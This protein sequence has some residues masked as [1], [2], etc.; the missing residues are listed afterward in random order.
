MEVAWRGSGRVRVRRRRNCEGKDEPGGC[1]RV[2]GGKQ[3]KYRHLFA[4]LVRLQWAWYVRYMCSG[5]MTMWYRFCC[6]TKLESIAMFS[7]T[8]C[9]FLRCISLSMSGHIGCHSATSSGLN[10]GSGSG[11]SWAA[12][13]LQHKLVEFFVHDHHRT[14]F[15]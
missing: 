2:L 7:W 3:G 6:L 15:N 8:F 11:L 10:P 5:S 1:A 13:R 14:I 9:E 12:V 4:C